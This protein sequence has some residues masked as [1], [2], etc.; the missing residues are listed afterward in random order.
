MADALREKVALRL[1]NLDRARDD[2]PPL[3]ALTELLSVGQEHYRDDADA[4]IAAVHAHDA[5]QPA[6]PPV[7]E[8]G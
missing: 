5:A 3:K 2:L 4:A 6:S 7:R 8:G 1:A